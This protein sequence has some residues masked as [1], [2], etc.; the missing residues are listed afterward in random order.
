MATYLMFGKYSQEGMKGISAERT[1]KAEDAI[2]KL[3]GEVK[4]GYA[5][6]GETDLVIIAEFPGTKQAMQAS[7]ALTKMTGIS[8]TTSPA[9]KMDNFDKLMAEV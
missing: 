4:E 6:L 2:K 1:K 9:V 3:D 7:A 8:F 5:L